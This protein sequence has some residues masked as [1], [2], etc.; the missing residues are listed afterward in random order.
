[1]AA[2]PPFAPPYAGPLP[3][4]AAPAPRTPR[5]EAPAVVLPPAN[6]AL[7]AYFTPRQPDGSF[8]PRSGGEMIRAMVMTADPATG[9][10]AYTDLEIAAAQQAVYPQQG[11]SAHTYPHEHR[12]KLKKAGFNPPP[13]RP[14]AI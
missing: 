4:A 5:A 2:A 3:P 14:A 6:P 1:V 9:T 11:T 8:K 7:V 10:C 13:P 12:G